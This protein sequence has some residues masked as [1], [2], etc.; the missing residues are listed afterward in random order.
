MLRRT[1]VLQQY[2]SAL[3]VILIKLKSFKMKTKY[4]LTTILL[5]TISLFSFAQTATKTEK[6]KVN[7]ECGM[8]KKHIETA[9]KEA[10]VAYASWNKDS[11]VLTVKY[12]STKTSTA[13]IETAVA[14]AGYDTQ[15]VKATDEAY[16][17]LDD[18]CQYKRE[19]VTTSS[20]KSC[21]DK[22]E[23]CNKQSCSSTNMAC[24]K[25]AAVKHSCYKNP[26]NSCCSK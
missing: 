7:G 26:V 21:C 22:N 4:F 23:I 25:N 14:A 10:G 16:K 13:K 3:T 19:A 24:C 18:C 1:L 17:K 6:I 12:A 5:V 2:Y 8:C 9:A 15:D 11:K 20:I